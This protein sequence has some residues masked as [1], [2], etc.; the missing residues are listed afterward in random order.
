[1]SNWY[2]TEQ[3]CFVW[4]V[5]MIDQ[6]TGRKVKALQQLWRLDITQD[7]QWRDVRLEVRLWI[8]KSLRVFLTML[9]MP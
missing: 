8:G 5:E 2:P 9:P 7:K 6:H 4:K 3:L 1:M